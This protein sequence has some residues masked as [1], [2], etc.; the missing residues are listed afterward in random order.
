MSIFSRKP[1]VPRND[2]AQRCRDVARVLI[3]W[4]VRGNG[5]ESP[6]SLL[7][8]AADEIDRLAANFPEG[9]HT[10]GDSAQSGQT[11]QAAPSGKFDPRPPR[12]VV[13]ADGYV[14]RDYGEYFSMCPVTDGNGPMPE[15]LTVYVP[16]SEIERGSGAA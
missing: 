12:L 7:F 13:D 6:G 16:L 10:S 4:T 8:E 11:P 15:P 2:V 9:D 14:W 1:K 3:G 5:T